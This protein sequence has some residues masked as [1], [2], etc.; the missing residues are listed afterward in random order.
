MLAFLPWL[1]VTKPLVKGP[2]HVF[3]QGVGDVPPADVASTISP[4]TM[5]KVLGQYRDS[6]NSPLRA[7]TVLRYDGRPLGTDFYEAGLPTH[8]AHSTWWR[9]IGMCRPAAAS[10]TPAQRRAVFVETV[11]VFPDKELG[12]EEDVHRPPSISDARWEYVTPYL[13]IAFG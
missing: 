4:E 9:L 6:A 7:V 2:F 13:T 8:G 5:A 11:D 12:V 1:R 10:H 3:P